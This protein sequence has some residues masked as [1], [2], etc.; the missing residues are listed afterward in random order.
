MDTPT[1]KVIINIALCACLFIVAMIA[2]PL[3]IFYIPGNENEVVETNQSMNNW[4][5]I[6]T[7]GRHGWQGPQDLGLAWFFLLNRKCR[8]QW[9]QA[10]GLAT[11]VAALS[12]KNWSWRPWPTR[13]S[14]YWIWSATYNPITTLSTTSTPALSAW[15]KTTHPCCYVEIKIH[16]WFHS[17]NV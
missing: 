9:Q 4:L 7:Q 8:R 16:C 1:R 5:H 11:T 3:V 13:S 14:L 2:I 17:P 15:P 12:A 6:Q 10:A